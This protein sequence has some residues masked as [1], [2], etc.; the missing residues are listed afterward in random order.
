MKAHRKEPDK[1]I[2]IAPVRL[3]QAQL[4]E[5]TQRSQES[6][7]TR[8]EYMRRR[9]LG[10]KITS[11]T[12]LTT[13]AQIHKIGVNINQ[14]ARVV[15]QESKVRHVANIEMQLKLNYQALQNILNEIKSK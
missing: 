1:H 7:L 8:S 9:I 15:N 3:T 6:G 12:D 13:I 14:I 5:I 2:K 10:K 4:E 11:K